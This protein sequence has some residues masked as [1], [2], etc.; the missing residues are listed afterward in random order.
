MAT[1][2]ASLVLVAFLTFNVLA[3]EADA[4][5]RIEFNRDVR[6][7]LSDNCFYCHGPDKGQ[8]QADLRLDMRDDAV[9]AR[10]IAPGDVA[11]SE[12]VARILTDDAELQMPPPE[13]RKKLTPRQKEILQ[14]WIAQ[15]AEY[16]RH[17]SFEPLA[18][19]Q[20]PRVKREAWARNDL[21]RFVLARLESEGLEPSTEASKETLIRRAAHR[22]DGPA[23]HAGRSGRLSGRRCG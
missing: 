1:V 22:S 17:W 9:K 15:G 6:P 23:A 2:A 5:D 18:P 13:S 16:E 7:I 21:D 8:R 20:V 4:A 11:A 3:A 19:V 12:L 10:A 14:K